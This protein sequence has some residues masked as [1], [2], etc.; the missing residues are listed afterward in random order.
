MRGLQTQEQ[1]SSR[2]I[3]SKSTEQAA[4][5][6]ENSSLHLNHEIEKDFYDEFIFPALSS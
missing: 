3:R 1:E 4:L 5:I 6:P 2:Q